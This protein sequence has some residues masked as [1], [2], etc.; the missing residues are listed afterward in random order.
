M[1][2]KLNR[3]RIAKD[4]SCL[5]DNLDKDYNINCGGCC[6]IAYII[7]K[8]LDQFQIE[9]SLCIVNDY[10]INKLAVI[11][12]VRNKQRH[13][14]LVTGDNTC[15]HYYLRVE[16]GGSINLGS[17]EG[18]YTYVISKINHRNIGWIYWNG[19]WNSTYDRRNNKFIKKI[20]SSYFRGYGKT[21]KGQIRIC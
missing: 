9:Y 8:Y 19:L 16:G 18:Y 4:L 20:I 6:F 3:H 10:P 21:R 17:F 12:E 13:F 14:N 11:K 2:K 1:S 15:C 5:C 7:S